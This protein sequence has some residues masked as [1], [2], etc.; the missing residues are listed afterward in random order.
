MQISTSPQTDNN[1]S[2]QFFTGQMPFPPLNQQ[3]QGTE[4]IK[5]LKA[6]KAPYQ[7]LE[8]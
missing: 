6:F 8:R 3:R 2:T 5:A 1:A 7:S 4:G